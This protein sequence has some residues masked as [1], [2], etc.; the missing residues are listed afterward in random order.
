MTPIAHIESPFS[1][2]FG[3]PRQSGMSSVEC[4]IVF[5]EGF[6]FPEAVRGLEEFDFIW[7]LWR[8]D[9]DGLWH[10][11]VRPPRLGGNRR[12]GVFSTRSP[13]RPNPIGLSSVRLLRVAFESC[14]PV[15]YVEGA[16]L[17]NNTAIYDIKPY[18]P[19]ADCH[20][21]ARCGFASQPADRRLK[22]VIP[23]SLNLPPSLRLTLCEILSLDPRPRYQDDSSRVY[24]L[25]Y[26]GR[27]VRFSVNDGTLTVLSALPVNQ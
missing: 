17:C 1:D 2:K 7:L 24:S 5:D 25:C 14:G 26:D 12:I 8:F 4:R 9:T 18:I 22:V 11:T 23:D 10:P 6:R 21:D 19:Y 3:I 13:F 15:L 20:P 27:E 16:D